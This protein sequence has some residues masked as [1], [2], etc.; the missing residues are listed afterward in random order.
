VDPLRQ[1]EARSYNRARRRL[2][3]ASGI[4]SLA[5]LI[6]VA[7]AAGQIGGWWTLVLLGPG[8]WLLEL[9]AGYAGYRLSRR[10]GLSRQDS[11]GWAADRVKGG[12]VGAVLGG[13]AVAAVIACQRQWPDGWV[14]AAW[15]AS[16]AFTALLAV[17]W[18]IL[19]LPIFLRS[20]PLSDGPLAAE[21]W[22]TANAAGVHV[23]EIRLLRMGEKTAAAN[24]MVAGL[25][26]T[27][28]IYVGDTLAEEQ[29]EPQEQAL[30]R[31]RVVLAHELG[32][33]VHRDIWR[34]LA[35]S[36]AAGAAGMAGAFLAVRA[37]APD[38][39]GHLTALP[40]LAL[41]YA[42]GSLIVSPLAA[43]YSRRRE[44]AADRYAVAL[45]G[46]GE[47][48]AQAIERL[49]RQNLTELW[50]PRLRHLLTASHPASGERIAAARGTPPTRQE[51]DLL[52]GTSRR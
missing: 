35:V 49:V 27:L 31:T 24:A 7:A 38:G 34:L 20:E 16:V 2:G 22:R 42:A 19:L 50:P 46:E 52:S 9:P 1:A 14:L 5:A 18:P 39:P 25:G 23:R 8:L 13:V 10:Y 36:A 37:L 48:F 21:M 29:D 40:V 43:A 15:L 30:A 47:T 6:A 26:P 41:G 3:L 28:R 17:I 12:L 32:H 33:H 11:R 44:R 45:T 51:L 4:V